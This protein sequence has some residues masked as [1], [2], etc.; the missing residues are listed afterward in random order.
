MRQTADRQASRTSFESKTSSGPSAAA[1]VG[2]ARSAGWHAMLV[3]ACVGNDEYGS[4][5][6]RDTCGHPAES[7]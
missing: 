4:D 6:P 2:P 5:G 3:T 7:N 1:V